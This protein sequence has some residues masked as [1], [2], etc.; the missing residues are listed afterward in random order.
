MQKG[1]GLM[2]V[3]FCVGDGDGVRP[4]GLSPLCRDMAAF[5]PVIDDMQADTIPLADFIDGE[6]SGWARRTGDPMFEADPAYHCGSE[7]LA[8][9]AREAL[10][11]EKSSDVP[12]V[13][14]ACQC[15]DSV[16]DARGITQRIG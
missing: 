2:L 11:I 7:G 6:R 15:S 10:A 3:L 9:R 5:D 4:P 12:I 16:D 1:F 14:L 13:V 8:G